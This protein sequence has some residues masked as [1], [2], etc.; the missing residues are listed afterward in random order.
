[1]RLFRV[2]AD[3]SVFGGCFDDEF[4]EVSRRFFQEVQD[5][6]FLLIVSELTLRELDRAPERVQTVLK[7]LDPSHLE[8]PETSVEIGR[9]RDAYLNAGIL[10]PSSANDAE[11]VAGA[12]VAGADI[13]VSW[14]FKHIVHY[15]K[16]AGF[17]AINLLQG[18]RPV[19]IYSPREVVEL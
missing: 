15:E 4:Q 6:R 1:M 5:G 8:L 16:I 18:Y 17:E 3:T 9:L 7:G 10:G 14:N 19:R 13:V 2:Y 11:H 12:T